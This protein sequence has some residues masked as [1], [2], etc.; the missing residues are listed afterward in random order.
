MQ[1]TAII[2]QSEDGSFGVYVPDLPGCISCGD[3]REEA[4]QSIQ[5][6]IRAHLEIMR[7]HGDDI[8]TPKSTAT[9]VNAA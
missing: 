1:Y 5:E 9:T 8:P 6:A 3:T 7:E 2:E 4:I